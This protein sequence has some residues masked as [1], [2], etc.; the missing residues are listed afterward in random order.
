[1]MS[2]KARLI[3]ILLGILV[4]LI[5]SYLV[6]R[7]R[8]YNIYAITWFL[9]SITFVSMGVFPGFVENLALLLGIYFTPAAILVVAIMGLGAIVLHL[10]IIV[11][12]QHKQIRHFEKEIALVRRQ[13]PDD[14]PLAKS[15]KT[16][17]V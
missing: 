8:L 9:A 5:V 1:M 15:Q 7:R 14:K 4:L 16:S 6:R 17:G 12:D 10:S 11:T 3:C 13:A 2:L